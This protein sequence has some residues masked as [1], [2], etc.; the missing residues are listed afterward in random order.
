MLHAHIIDRSGH[1]E[2][3]TVRDT[4]A[5]VFTWFK[6]HKIDM[7]DVIFSKDKDCFEYFRI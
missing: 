2:S 1:I 6:D 3:A 7:K 4:P 5:S